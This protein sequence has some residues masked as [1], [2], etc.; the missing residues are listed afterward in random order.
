M[1]RRRTESLLVSQYVDGVVRRRPDEVIVEEPMTIELDGVR[2]TTT[3]RTPGNDFELAVGFLHGEGL[4]GN[5]PVREVKYCANGSAV[6]SGFNI[7]TVSTD[8]SGPAPKARLAATT[9]S[10]GLCGNEAIDELVARLEPIDPTRVARFDLAL[11]AELPRRAE[12]YQPLFGA[13]GGVH[14]AVAVR[15]DGSPVV[16]REDVGR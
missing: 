14:A 9:S 11:L 7:V 3:M 8:G 6:E 16:A 12:G 13:T 4:L 1:A 2:V 10:C 15:T 5:A